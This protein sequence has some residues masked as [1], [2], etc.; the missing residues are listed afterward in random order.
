MSC[1]RGCS[2]TRMCANMEPRT[3]GIILIVV[4]QRREPDAEKVLRSTAESRQLNIT[5]PGTVS[6]ACHYTTHEIGHIISPCYMDVPCSRGTSLSRVPG[7]KGGSEMLALG[8]SGSFWGEGENLFG[9]NQEAYHDAAACLIRDGEML[10]ASE[11]ER[12]NRIK[13]T[14][15]FPVNAV[16]ACL[17]TAK[18]SPSDIDVVGYYFEEYQPDWVLMLTY[19]GD[20]QLRI[21]SSRELMMGQLA[22]ELGVNL[23][24]DRLLYVQHHVSHA[25]PCFI[26]SGMKDAL[27]AVMDAAGEEHST[28]IFRGHH[29]QLERLAAY[30][31]DKSFGKFYWEAIG[32]LAYNLGDEYKVMGLAPYGNPD[33]YRNIFGSMYTLRDG[34]DFDLCFRA[35]PFVGRGFMRRRKGQ[36]F[37]QQHMDF[38]AGLQ[39]TLE[40]VAMHVLV[41]WAKHTGLRNL[42]FVGGVALNSSLNGRIL[43]SGE[44]REV[45]IHPAAHDAGGAEGA[46]LDAARQLGAPPFALPR[47]RSASVGPDLGTAAE[48]EKELDSWGDLVGYEQPAD[49][50]ATAARLLADGAVLGWAQGRSEYGPRALGNRSI[51]ADSRPSENKQRIN[52]MVKKRE[53]YRPFAPVVTAEAASTYFDL[54]DTRA[55]YD[56]MSFVVEVRD[57]KRKELGAVTHI[58]G[59]ARV[60]VIDRLSNGRFHELVRKFGD[61]TGTPVLLNTSF[62]NNAEPIVQTVHDALTCFLT[63]ELDFLVI[64]DFLIRRRPGCSLAF[65]G[66][67]PR[68]RPVTRLTKR[69]RATAADASE[70]VYEI[71]VRTQEHGEQSAEISRTVFGLLEAADGVR[72]LESLAETA[73]DLDQDTLREIY[74]LWQ[75]RFFIL[76]PPGTS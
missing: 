44:F 17:A 67:V 6:I 23:S 69:I 71:S 10:A 62:N 34:G 21:P 40:T 35:Q 38:A 42:C 52:S 51:L 73:G 46:A 27:V 14:A 16:R 29:G 1:S 65:N 47:M 61:L 18:V 41:Y 36:A 54:P 37:T 45:F 50:L 13:K 49:I 64:E 57:D 15:K 5:R 43:R 9:D 7:R 33:T 20:P 25:L 19:E 12:F 28:T 59:S 30:P 31:I 58:D 74:S 66:L 24:T 60:Q 4:S 75:G 48:I 53:A 72:T 39:Q 32:L 63:T 8:L 55:N 3:S 11:E 2:G 26:R 68:F 76:R 22:G 56:F 70:V